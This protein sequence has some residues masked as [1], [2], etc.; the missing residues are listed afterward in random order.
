M[1]TTHDTS[2]VVS[3]AISSFSICTFRIPLANIIVEMS[4]YNHFTVMIILV[5][6]LIPLTTK[7]RTGTYNINGSRPQ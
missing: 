4:H 2:I 1:F 5:Y 6:Y 3:I 7:P